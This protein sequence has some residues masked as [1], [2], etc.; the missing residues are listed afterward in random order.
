MYHQISNITRSYLSIYYNCE[1]NLF[2]HKKKK[3]RIKKNETKNFDINSTIK[4]IFYSNNLI[5]FTQNIMKINDVSMQLQLFTIIDST[6]Q[7]K[8]NEEH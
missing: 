8:K 4:F 6:L 7:K 2:I 1:Y 3:E 5:K